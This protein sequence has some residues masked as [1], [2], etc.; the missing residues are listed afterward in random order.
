[1]AHASQDPADIRKFCPKIDPR[2]ER[3]IL[4][5]LHA[6]PA[7]RPASMDELL[8]MVKGVERETAA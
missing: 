2:L 3:A 7:E 5:C 1:M 6:N 4:A 8:K